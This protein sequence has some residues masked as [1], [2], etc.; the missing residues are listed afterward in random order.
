MDDV[1]TKKKSMKLLKEHYE[2]ETLDLAYFG[3]VAKLVSL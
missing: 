3:E 2:L 1:V